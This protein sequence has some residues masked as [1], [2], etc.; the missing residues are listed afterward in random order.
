MK[1]GRSMPTPTALMRPLPFNS[2]M[3]R[4]PLV[5]SWFR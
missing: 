2:S 1:P 5:A 3:A 4:Q